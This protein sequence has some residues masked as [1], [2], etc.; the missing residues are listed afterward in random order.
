MTNYYPMENVGNFFALHQAS[1]KLI[2]V[3]L[4]FTTLIHKNDIKNFVVYPRQAS[5]KDCHL[6]STL[7]L[8]LHNMVNMIVAGLW[9]LFAAAFYITSY[10]GQLY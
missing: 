4:Q 3:L 5:D 8:H 7:Q 10:A 6:H 1:S 2:K 9:F